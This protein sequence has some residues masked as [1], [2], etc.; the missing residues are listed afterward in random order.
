QGIF[1]L[2]FFWAWVVA[3]L[4]RSGWVCAGRTGE[5]TGEG[6]VAALPPARA[7]QR[8]ERRSS[9]AG[10]RIVEAGGSGLWL[11]RHR[12]LPRLEAGA[13][14]VHVVLLEDREAVELLQL[15]RPVGRSGLEGRERGSQLVED[16]VAGNVLAQPERGRDL[17]PHGARDVH[18]GPLRRPR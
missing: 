10:R 18:L 8:I 3:P 11:G 7:R 1:L 9:V 15:V 17:H 16:G 4:S 6:A 12:L 2:S 14:G 13:Q 5:G